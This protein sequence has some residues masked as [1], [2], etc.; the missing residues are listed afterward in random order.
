[1]SALTYIYFDKNTSTTALQTTTT[2]ASA[3]G[4]GKILMGVA[5]DSVEEA[6]FQ[7]FSG[8][9]GTRISGGDV[10]KESIRAAQI[11]ADTIL[12]SNIAADTITANE[13]YPNTITSSE[14]K[15]GTITTTELNFTPVADNNVIATINASSE[16]IAID[17]DNISI[18]GSSTFSSGYDPTDKV[19]EIGGS[20]DSAG[21]NPRVRI[22]PDANTGI[23]VIDDEGE[24]VFKAVV[25]GADVGNVIIGNYAGGQGLM[26][27]KDDGNIYYKNLAWSEVVDD[28]GNAPDPNATEGADF[29]V[30]IG[31]GGTGNNDV[32]NDG[33][34]TLYRNHVFG[35]GSDSDVIVNSD[36]TMTEDWY[37]NNLTVNNGCTLNPGGYRIFVKETL[38]NAG[39]IARVGGNGGNG[40]D[41]GTGCSSSHSDTDGGTAGGSLA[42]GFLPGAVGG[43]AGGNGA[44]GQGRNNDGVAG[45]AGSNGQATSNSIGVTS[46]ASGGIGGNGGISSAENGASGGAGG[47]GRTATQASAQPKTLTE[48]LLM[49][50]FEDEPASLFGGSASGGS[51]GGGASGGGDGNGTSQ[52]SGSGGA[53]GG[54]GGC[55]GTVVI[56]ARKIVNTGTISVKG[57]SG[58]N[59]GDAGASESEDGRA[60]GG[61]GGGGGGAGGS[62]GI[63]FLVYNELTDSGTITA[64]GGAGGTG[65]SKSTAGSCGD[66]APTTYGAEDGTDGLNGNTGTTGK[67]IQLEV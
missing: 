33:V 27:D 20:Y 46:T 29:G 2:P 63:L 59:G 1:M 56:L 24:D 44:V 43:A 9:G 26:Y 57:G 21:S 23:Q 55:G 19:A 18:S 6:V 41:G 50:N 32:S 53:G 45:D 10:E 36:T 31:G 40:E 15:A 37:C 22:F 16:G 58:G 60:A 3:V 65:G 25:G 11:A 49:R 52:F 64:A 7:I 48:L 4:S 12:A 5:E 28:D 39:T 35:D 67:I 8:S 38:T 66:D 34:V 30:N 51:G 54:S 13:I 62:G 14:I 47:N 61:S 17:A 42:A